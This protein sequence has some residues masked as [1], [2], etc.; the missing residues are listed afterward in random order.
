[1]FATE[2]NVR[3]QTS[4]TPAVKSRA[5]KTVPGLAK[6]ILFRDSRR[7]RVA[8][9]DLDEI[10]GERQHPHIASQRSRPAAAAP[11]EA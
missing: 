3:R 11:V 6:E 5:R 8:G 2:R 1:L 7:S 9:G 4:D 10:V